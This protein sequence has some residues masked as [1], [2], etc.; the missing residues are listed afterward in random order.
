[1]VSGTFAQKQGEQHPP[2]LDRTLRK[3]FATALNLTT[4]GSDHP[5][6]FAV[7]LNPF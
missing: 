3:A 1:M 5:V 7:L 6:R 2:I 4:N